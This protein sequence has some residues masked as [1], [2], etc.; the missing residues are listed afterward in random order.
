MTRATSTGMADALEPGPASG[1][2]SCGD[3]TA[4]DTDVLVFPAEPPLDAEGGMPPDFTAQF[5]TSLARLTAALEGRGAALSQ[6]L[7]AE[8]HIT[9]GGAEIYDALQAAFLDGFAMEPRPARCVSAATSLTHGAV[10]EIGCIASL[11]PV[12]PPGPLSA[13]VAPDG[14]APCAPFPHARVCRGGVWATAQVGSDPSTGSLAPVPGGSEAQ[15]RQAIGNLEAILRTSG[16]ALEHVVHARVQYVD[17]AE[18]E[19][20]AA[21]VA[22]RPWPQDRVMLAQVPFIPTAQAGVT[23]KVDAVARRA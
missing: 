16:S 1:L 13:V 23:V 8:I 22:G 11:T 14:P 7:R 15:L 20:L 5:R 4:G 2:N 19:A 21:I 10:V 3:M 9:E 17:E 6:V 18:R 12:S